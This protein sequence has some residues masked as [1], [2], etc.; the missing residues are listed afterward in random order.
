MCKNGTHR[1][2]SYEIRLEALLVKRYGRDAVSTQDITLAGAQ[3]PIDFYIRPIDTF[4]EVDGEYWHGLDRPIEEIAELKCRGDAKVLSKWQWDR[5]LDAR[6]NRERTRLIRI[7]DRELDSDAW[8]FETWIKKVEME[9]HG[10][11]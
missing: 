2:S 3:H 7:T 5:E 4:I 1:R 9:A 8:N 6:C 10:N 11:S